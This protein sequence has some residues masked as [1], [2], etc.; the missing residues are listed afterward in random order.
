M[1]NI[2]KK[3]NKELKINVLVIDPIVNSKYSKQYKHYNDLYNE[4][5]KV[6]NCHL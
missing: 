3:N 1:F 5:S 4:L 6:C 2:F